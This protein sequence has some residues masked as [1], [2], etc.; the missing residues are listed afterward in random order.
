MNESE[1]TELARAVGY[2]VII[3]SILIFFLWDT[4]W[5]LLVLF[6]A[7]PCAETIYKIMYSKLDIGN[8]QFSL[9]VTEDELDV[10]EFG[11]VIAK[12]DDNDCYEYLVMKNPQT[13]E[14]VRCE[15][16][17]VIV[18]GV[19]GEIEAERMFLIYNEGLYLGPAP[20]V[21]TNNIVL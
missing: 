18:N 17:S 7:V 3:A 6:F 11:P 14:N 16:Q 10:V 20:V 9:H 12:Y 21:Q 1:L 13:N 4:W 5:V 19:L 15:F 2:T 8:A